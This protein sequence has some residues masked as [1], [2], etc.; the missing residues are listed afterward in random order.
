MILR[1]LK[2][3]PHRVVDFALINDEHQPLEIVTDRK[4]THDILP[5]E[6]SLGGR[7][8]NGSFVIDVDSEGVPTQ[9]REKP[10]E[11]TIN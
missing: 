11:I 5:A 6:F 7:Y 4:R 2:N 10:A 1:E 8:S 3:H 9:I